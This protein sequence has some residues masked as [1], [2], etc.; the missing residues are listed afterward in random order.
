MADLAVVGQDP[1]FGGG[2]LAQ[3]DAFLDGA[4]GLGRSPV[5]VY[6]PHPTL[7]GQRV[8][9]DRVEALRQLRWAR[10]LAPGLREPRSVWVAATIATHGLAAA[11][12]G[13]RYGAWIGT[14]L[15][16]E[17]SGRARSLDPLRRIAQRGNAPALRRL[18]RTVLREAA[19]VYATSPASRSAIAAAGGLDEESVGILPIPI[20]VERFTPEPDEGWLRRLESP[21]IAFVGRADDPRKNLDLLLEALPA[22][23][24][25]I[26]GARVVLAG[27]PPARLPEGATA[28]GHVD[29]LPTVL[30]Q[31]S[32]FVLPSWQEGFGIVAAEALAAGVPVVTTPSGGPEHLVLASGGGR[33]LTSFDAEELA[34]VVAATL[35]DADTL[36][37][38]RVAGR[39]HIVREHAP[40]RFRS[41]LAEALDAVDAVDAA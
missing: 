17:W 3:L 33:V 13:R 4:R 38:M 29:D 35:E 30:R 15:D 31:A 26:P 25:R 18:E 6:P 28:L 8:T 41:L 21:A 40:E 11:R 32:L 7:A 27:R 20:D 24:R 34:D 16:D 1:G 39:E 14:S 2:A 9:P 12:S 10:R 37:R 5:L 36:L 19:R 22:I 23:R